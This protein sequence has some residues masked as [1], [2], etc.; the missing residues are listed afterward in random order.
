MATTM[1]TS[2]ESKL[3]IMSAECWDEQACVEESLGATRS[4]KQ[5]LAGLLE[6]MLLACGAAFVTTY[7]SSDD[8]LIAFY[9]S[10]ML[11]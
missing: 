7:G 8:E 1:M 4:L 9:H 6:S 5:K 10:W 2:T 11:S 3:A